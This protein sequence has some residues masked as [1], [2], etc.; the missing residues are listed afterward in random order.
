MLATASGTVEGLIIDEPRGGHGFGY[1]PHFLVPALGLTTAEMEPE[2]KN[3]LS[4]RGEAL[5]ALWPKLRA[6]LTA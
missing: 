4:H 6:L 1:D 3:R 5:R 2:Q